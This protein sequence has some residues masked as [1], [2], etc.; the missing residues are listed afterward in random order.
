MTRLRKAL[1]AAC[2]A[3]ALS[4]GLYFGAT[5]DDPLPY[6]LEGI[7]FPTVDGS[8][9]DL[10]AL[11]GRVTVINFWATWCPPC[12]EEM[13]ELDELYGLELQPNGVELI[14][15]ALDKPEK[16]KHFLTET[17]VNYPILVAGLAGTKLANAMGNKQGGLP[18]TVILDEEGRTL[19][20]KA[21]RIHM[22]TIRIALL[23]HP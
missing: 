20:K 2:G 19:L 5:D 22:D 1:F 23:T 16:V 8:R 13:P 11:K 7:H 15:I 17:P 9:Y 10:H 21:G 3:L 4:L 12:V 6:P 14:G 18:Y